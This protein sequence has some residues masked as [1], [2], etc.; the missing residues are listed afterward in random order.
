MNSKEDLIEKRKKIDQKGKETSEQLKEFYQEEIEKKKKICKDFAKVEDEFS[1]RLKIWNEIESDPSIVDNDSWPLQEET[2]ERDQEAVQS[3]ETY[4]EALTAGANLN[5][6]EVAT[7]SGTI[8]TNV[9]SG[10]PSLTS[11]IRDYNLDKLEIEIQETIWG[12][13]K[14]IKK[15]LNDFDPKFAEDLEN[16]IQE[17]A[18]LPDNEKWTILTNLRDFIFTRFFEKAGL[19]T[20]SQFKNCPWFDESSQ[21][22]RTPQAKYFIQGCKDDSEFPPPI[23]NVINNTSKQI[24]RN[25]HRLSRLGKNGGSKEETKNAIRNTLSSFK[26]ALELN[27]QYFSDNE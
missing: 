16:I 19:S 9:T 25:H 15:R 10:T 6:R 14:D 13:L 18:S 5:D 2:M 11:G 26:N 3:L 23:L 24:K 21:G 20:K 12:D 8:V 1:A 7:V 22:I 17:W 4:S 27:N